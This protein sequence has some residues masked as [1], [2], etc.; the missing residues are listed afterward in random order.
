MDPR[1]TLTTLFLR[2][3][4]SFFFL[5][6]NLTDINSVQKFKNIDKP[7]FTSPSLT[8]ASSRHSPQS[9]KI[10]VEDFDSDESDLSETDL[11]IHGRKGRTS[12]SR[13]LEAKETSPMSVQQS[14]RMYH[15]PQP[16]RRRRRRSFDRSR[17]AMITFDEQV[18]RTDNGNKPRPIRRS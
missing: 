9:T 13:P 15:S 18:Q 1:F 5:N 6:I 4:A 8:P 12:F 11:S 10:F 3:Y 14:L 2:T 17:P 16:G 7:R